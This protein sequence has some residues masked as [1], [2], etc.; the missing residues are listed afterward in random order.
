M[1]GTARLPLMLAWVVAAMQQARHAFG[2][3][4]TASL[5]WDAA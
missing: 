5:S 4:L 1:T 2:A 3:G